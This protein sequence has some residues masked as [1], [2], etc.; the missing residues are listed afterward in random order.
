MGNIREL[1][2]HI[3]KNNATDFACKTNEDGTRP[4]RSVDLL[5]FTFFLLDVRILSSCERERYLPNLTKEQIT[6]LTI[7]QELENRKESKVDKYNLTDNRASTTPLFCPPT[8][9]FKRFFI[10]VLFP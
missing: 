5:D 9:E 3:I 2:H 10:N 6:K 7:L 8:T 4:S 1:A